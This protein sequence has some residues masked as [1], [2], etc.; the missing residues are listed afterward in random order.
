[1][2]NTARRMA[3]PFAP[4]LARGLGVPLTAVT[5]L[6]AVNQATAVIGPL[7]ALFADRY[8]NKPVLLPAVA[9]CFVGCM[10]I[11]LFPLYGVV[12]TGLFLAGFAKTLFDPSLQAQIGA[13]VPYAQR[14]KFI[15]I[16]ETS[17]AG[18]TL[19]TIPAAGL[20]ISRFSW[21]TPFKILAVLTLICFFFLFKLAPGRNRFQNNLTHKAEGTHRVRVNWKAL[22]RRKEVAGLLIFVF[23]MSLANANR[24]FHELWHRACARIQGGHHGDIFCRGRNRQDHRSIFRR[25]Y[26]VCLRHP[27]H[28]SG[29]GHLFCD[30]PGSSG[31]RNPKTK[32]QS[33]D[34]MN[35]NFLQYLY[36]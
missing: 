25:F 32:D 29:F 22:I 6:I 34:S 16:T 7:G 4:E 19:L 17:W 33:L 36:K 1:M 35:Y 8:G 24:L 18:A 9:L 5:S 26:L 3:Y 13:Q 20:I 2:L 11:A 27:R 15:G 12:L 14:G 21:Q 23:F 31:C 28:L 10:D 30:G